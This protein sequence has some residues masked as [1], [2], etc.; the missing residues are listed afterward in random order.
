[1]SEREQLALARVLEVF[2]ETLEGR[3]SLLRAFM[4]LARLRRLSPSGL[5]KG[6]AL[7]RELVLAIDARGGDAETLATYLRHF[8][9]N[10]AIT[11][12]RAAVPPPDMPDEIHDAPTPRP[13]RVQRP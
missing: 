5:V 9:W 12:K 8:R 2:A 1:M 6:A 13:S 3:R 4:S 10:G 11:R 7:V